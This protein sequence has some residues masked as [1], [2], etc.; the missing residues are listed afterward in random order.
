L[1]PRREPGVERSAV[2]IPSAELRLFEI[3]TEFAV[4]RKTGADDL[5][6]LPDRFYKLN[7]DHVYIAIL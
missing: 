7:I 4:E 1:G 2:S 5:Y 6:D 3:T